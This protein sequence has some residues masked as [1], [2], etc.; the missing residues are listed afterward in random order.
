MDAAP[1]NTLSTTEHLRVSPRGP[2]QRNLNGFI[3]QGPKDKLS[4]RLTP[5]SPNPEQPKYSHPE[6]DPVNKK[7]IKAILDGVKNGRS[8]I[9][10]QSEIKELLGEEGWDTS[11]VKN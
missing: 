11:K 10:A 4:H 1:D 2:K 8:E 3:V 6:Q 5:D 9:L 7:K